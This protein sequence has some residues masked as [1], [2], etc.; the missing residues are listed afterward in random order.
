MT[1][2]LHINLNQGLVEAEGS[3]E[4][5]LKVYNDF[6]DKL[7]ETSFSNSFNP[8]NT[9]GVTASPSGAKSANVSQSTKKAKPKAKQSTNNSSKESL[10]VVPEFFNG[11][12][13]KSFLSEIKKYSLPASHQKKATLFIYVM[14]N[15]GMQNITI[16]HVFTCYRLLT[17]KTPGNLRQTIT[18]AK[19]KNVWIVNED[20]GDLKTHYKGDEMVEHSLIASES[21]DKASNA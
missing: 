11:T 12:E 3:E 6:K 10:E 18:D 9:E 21:T 20:W 2:K 13:S 15:I 7:S 5:V 8:A 16:N 1:A 4:F 17:E 19:N 14:Q